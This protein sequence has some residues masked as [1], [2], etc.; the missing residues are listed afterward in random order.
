[1][2][3]FRIVRVGLP[4]IPRPRL[5]RAGLV[6]ALKALAQSDKLRTVASALGE[7]IRAETGVE[8][9][10]RLIEET[11]GQLACMP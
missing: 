10:V 5:N 8:K 1:L 6:A 4:P 3:Q 2:A 9:A 11:F 7:Q